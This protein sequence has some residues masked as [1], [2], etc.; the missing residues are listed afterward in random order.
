MQKSLIVVTVLFFHILIFY[1][2]AP[3]RFVKP[4][5]K[6]Q[7]A[8]NL[9]LGGPLIGYSGLTIPMPFLTATYGYGIDS[10]LTGFGLT[11]Y[12]FLPFM[13]T[14]KWKLVLPKDSYNSKV[15]F[16]R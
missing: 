6:K 5:D 16:L 8:V 14:C 15:T 12:Y 4:L 11:K 7:Q 13:A 10:T 9:S 2:C 1:S 3:T